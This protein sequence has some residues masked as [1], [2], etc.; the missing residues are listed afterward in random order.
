MADCDN[1]G[2]MIQ[3]KQ[4]DA[5]QHMTFFSFFYALES[6][7]SKFVMEDMACNFFLFLRN[8]CRK[9]VSRARGKISN[10]NSKHLFKIENAVLVFIERERE[11]EDRN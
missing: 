7:I 11:R 4:N 9:L 2:K 3:M 8:Y 10:K 1:D 5:I 6:S